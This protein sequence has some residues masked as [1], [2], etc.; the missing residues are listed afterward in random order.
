MLKFIRTVDKSFEDFLVFN[1]KTLGNLVDNVNDHSPYTFRYGKFRRVFGHF[2][3][4][5][6][7]SFANS[8]STVT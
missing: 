4:K 1:L 6:S 5:S 2:A 7:D 3:E 8:T